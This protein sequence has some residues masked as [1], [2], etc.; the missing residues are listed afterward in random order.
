MPSEAIHS[1]T[2]LRACEPHLVL[3]DWSY[4]IFSHGMLARPLKELC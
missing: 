3:T 1:D 4:A 2:E